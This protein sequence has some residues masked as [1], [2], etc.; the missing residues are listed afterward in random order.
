MIFL[1]AATA[2]L[3]AEKR[4]PG[5]KAII[6]YIGLKLNTEN[7][8]EPDNAVRTCDKNGNYK[9]I[10]EFKPQGTRKTIKEMERSVDVNWDRKRKTI[11]KK[12]MNLTTLMTLCLTGTSLHFDCAE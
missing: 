2:H 6:K 7:N 4:K 3:W 1:K 8:M 12:M 5:H 11:L 10:T 9:N